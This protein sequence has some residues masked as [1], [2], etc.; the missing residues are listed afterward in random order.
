LNN[1]SRYHKQSGFKKQMM[2]SMPEEVQYH[3]ITLWRNWRLPVEIV[4]V[5]YHE[6]QKKQIER[7]EVEARQAAEEAARIEVSQK[8]SP[9]A[10]VLEEKVRVLE[11]ADGERVRVEVESYEDLAV[12]PQEG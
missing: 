7:S 3:G 6:L 2:Y 4:S 1:I 9:G 11:S 12:Y 10:S 8:I 5:T